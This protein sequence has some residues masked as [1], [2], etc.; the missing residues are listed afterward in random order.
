MSRYEWES[1]KFTLPSKDVAAVKGAVRD[2]ANRLHDNTRARVIA[3]HKS[4]ATTSRTKYTERL[5][6]ATQAH[7]RAFD[8]TYARRSHDD[9]LASDACAFAILHCRLMNAPEGK[10]PKQPTISDIARFAPRYTSRDT[11]FQCGSDATITFEGRTVHYVVSENNHAREHADRDP[12]VRAF[13][14]ALN[15]VNWTRGTGGYTVGND[16][17]NRDNSQPGGGGNYT[18]RRYGS[19]GQTA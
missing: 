19:L 6:A 10:A 5:N 8:D 2:T 15:R 1:G 14:A 11:R 12:I 7:Y 17:Y 4:F 13:F 16:E 3:L 18:L 9:L